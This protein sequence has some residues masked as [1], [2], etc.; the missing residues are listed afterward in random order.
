M[1]DLLAV[2]VSQGI[3]HLAD[4]LGRLGLVEPAALLLLQALVK[5]PPRSKLQDEVDSAL[6]IKVSKQSQDV[7]VSK[8]GLNLYFTSKVFKLK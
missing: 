3:C 5:L 4:V 6:V 8:V 1:D 7:V 2:A